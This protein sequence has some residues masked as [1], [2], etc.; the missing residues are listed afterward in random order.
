ME[1]DATGAI[2]KKTVNAFDA[3]GNRVTETETDAAGNLL[4]KTLYT[5]NS[6]NLKTGKTNAAGSKQKDKSKKWEY[7]YY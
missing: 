4:K 3:N 2:R 7:V 5:Y 1:Y 6:K